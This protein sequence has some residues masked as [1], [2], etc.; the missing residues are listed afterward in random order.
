MENHFR[1]QDD[2][3]AIMNMYVLSMVPYLFT[4]RDV[5][6]VPVPHPKNLYNVSTCF[7]FLD[8]TNCYPT[9]IVLLLEGFILLAEYIELQKRKC[10]N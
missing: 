1:N 6:H 2:G 8:N 4:Q 5:T 3:E 9:Q 10:V 7:L